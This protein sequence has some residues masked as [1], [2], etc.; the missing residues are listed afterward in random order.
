[1]PFWARRL[2]KDVLT[3]RQLSRRGGEF[4]SRDA[5]ERVKI[6]GSAVLYLEGEIRV[7]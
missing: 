6:C 5:G 3:S 4:A 1:V 7:K 2:G